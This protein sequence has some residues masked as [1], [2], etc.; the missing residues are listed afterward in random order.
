MNE[1][2]IFFDESGVQKFIRNRVEFGI[3]TFWRQLE[4]RF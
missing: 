1:Y 4:N 2:L 3:F